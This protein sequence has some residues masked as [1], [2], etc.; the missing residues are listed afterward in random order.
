ME[1][2]DKKKNINAFR[3]SQRVRHQH[4]H[5]KQYYCITVTPK[6]KDKSHATLLDEFNS[7][8][9]LYKCVH[10]VFL[11]AESDNTKHFHGIVITK[12]K[13]MFKKL[14]S[15]KNFH[16][17]IKELIPLNDWCTYMVKHLPTKLHHNDHVEFFN[18]PF[19]T[20][21]QLAHYEP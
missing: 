5:H 11:I 6:G 15:N 18:K 19:I 14:Y 7:S 21:K 13:C 20:D 1:R 4:R 9:S 10:D 16:F 12:D 8:I 3:L 17:H 2:S